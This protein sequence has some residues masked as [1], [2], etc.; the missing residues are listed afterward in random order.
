MFWFFFKKTALFGNSA[1]GTRKCKKYYRKE[2]LFLYAP[3]SFTE[4][5]NTW[6]ARGI[7]LSHDGKAPTR[8]DGNGKL[9]FSKKF[10]CHT[11]DLTKMHLLLSE[12][13]FQKKKYCRPE[14]NKREEKNFLN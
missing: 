7:L 2:I 8:T 3:F 11:V 4:I 13:S 14:K 6:E 12:T 10:M 1:L 9:H 5:T